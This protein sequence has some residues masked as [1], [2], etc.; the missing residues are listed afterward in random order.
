MEVELTKISGV[1]NE[2]FRKC[3]RRA[4][5]SVRDFNVEFAR[6]VLRLHEVRCELPPR[7]GCTLTNSGCR[8]PKNLP[9]L[10]V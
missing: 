1:M 8:K 5:Q 3:R 9:S 6:L 7:A 4:D 10:L 2:L